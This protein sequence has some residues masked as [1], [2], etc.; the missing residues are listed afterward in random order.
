MNAHKKEI[1]LVLITGIFMPIFLVPL[2]IG[3]HSHEFILPWLHYLLFLFLFLD[4]VLF[5]LGIVFLIRHKAKRKEK[6]HFS[7]V[8]K[9]LIGFFSSLSILGGST[10]LILMYGPWSFFRDWLIS[11]AMTTMTHRYLATWFYSREEIEKV[12]EANQI[13]E[14]DEETDLNLI[15]IRKNFNQEYYPN[16]YERDIFTVEDIYAPYKIIPISGKNYEGYL[17]VIYDPSRVSVATTSYLNNR[18]EYVTEMASKQNA[19]LAVNGG[20]FSDPNQKG[21][22]GTPEG[23]LISN[24]K[25]LSNKGYDRS[26]GLIGFTEDNKLILGKMNAKEAK[27]KKVRDAVSFGPFLIVNG[28]RSFIKG[29]GGWGNAPRTA[30]G[31][32][33]DGIVLLL[34]LDGRKL[35]V[36][37]ATMLDLTNVLAN[38][39]AYNAAN[40]DGGT[41]TVMVLPKLEAS[42]YISEKD[43]KSHCLNDY[44]YINDIVNGSGAHVTRPIV[45]SIIVK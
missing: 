11:S 38:Y 4:I 35:S 41:S 40:L 12:L 17:A 27:E 5:V 23:V 8:A 19:L 25:V 15:E 29:N 22:G 21:S 45:S 10:F 34:V 31:Q 2:V 24:G 3:F 18:G 44:C 26:G 16:D 13:I 30:I 14:I 39:G 6:A 20:G 28:K 33:Q 7:L 32:R 42:K 1:I 9:I 37:G 43:M 36:P